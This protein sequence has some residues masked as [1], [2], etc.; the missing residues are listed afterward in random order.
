MYFV[1]IVYI[2]SKVYVNP[3]EGNEQIK[4]LT[5]HY[6]TLFLLL[7]YAILPNV[8]STIAGAVPCTAVDPNSV[9]NNIGNHYLT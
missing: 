7:T 5:G 3:N 2:R 4:S 9:D 1:E 8:S 6:I